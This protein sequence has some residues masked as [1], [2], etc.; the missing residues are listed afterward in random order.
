MCF[1][2]SLKAISCRLG[3]K[4]R[5]QARGQARQ[6]SYGKLAMG[7]HLRPGPLVFLAAAYSQ[8][9]ALLIQW[10]HFGIFPSHRI[11]RL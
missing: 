11:L 9:A 6:P 2:L 7:P 3:A 10:E 5:G 4:S 8:S 1:L